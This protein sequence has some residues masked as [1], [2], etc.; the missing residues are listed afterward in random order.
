MKFKSL[1]AIIVLASIALGGCKREKGS[2]SVKPG[3][4]AVQTEE[5]Q[6]TETGQ[7]LLFSGNVEGNKTVRLGFLVAGKINYIAVQEGETINKGA[8]LSSLDPEDYSIA[9]ELAD[10]KLAQMQD[11][12]NR[13]KELYERKSATESDFIKTANGLRAA[14]AEQRLHAKNLK[15]TKLYSPVKGVMLKRGV[16]EGEI[17]D[18]GLQV[19]VISDI[20]EVKVNGAVPETELRYITIGN[21]AKVYIASLDSTFVGTI[22]E[23]GSL[24]DPATRSFSVKTAIKNPDLLIR[25][26]MT[27]EVHIET[28]K[29]KDVISVPAEAVLHDID[30]S[31]YVYV[32]DTIRK[33]AFN[34]KVSLGNI[35]GNNIEILSGLKKKELVITG[36]QHKLSNGTSIIL[37]ER[38]I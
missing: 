5:V 20:Y 12:Y 3:S 35:V 17:I 27:A 15:D 32:A 19:F 14:K 21:P 7:Q 30:H 6:F 33:Q 29:T 31:S 13:V 8:L 34:R 26:G 23:I 16:E 38:G 1:T 36:G 10:V 28:G 37:N 4:I 22:R 18:K 25:P 11:D 24:A 9:K 2:D